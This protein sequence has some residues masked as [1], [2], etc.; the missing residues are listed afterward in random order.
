MNKKDWTGQKFGK[1]TFIEPVSVMKQLGS[2]RRTVW[3]LR[4]DCGN[5]TQAQPADVSSRRV[6]SCGCMRRRKHEPLMSSAR[7]VWKLYKELDFETFYTLSQCNCHY[8]GSPP[9]RSFNIASSE[10]NAGAY[11]SERQLA[12]GNFVYN[13]LDRIDSNKEHTVDNVVTC[14]YP[15]NR[16]KSDMSQAL[17]LEHITRIHDHQRN[18][19]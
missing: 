10:K 19:S 14:C 11:Q 12:E 17:F 3:R 6:S 15:C 1:L 5:T 16:M 2:K 18:D 9:T 13:G 4:C 7:C 8:C